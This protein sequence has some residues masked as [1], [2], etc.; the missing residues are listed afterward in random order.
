[1]NPSL[2]IGQGEHRLIPAAYNIII[3]AGYGI[4]HEAIR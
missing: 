4:W 1:L 2:I 3:G